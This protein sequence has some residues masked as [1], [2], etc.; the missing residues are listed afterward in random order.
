MPDIRTKRVYEPANKKDGFCVLVDR[1]WPRG[2]KKEQ[3]RSD[4]WLKDVAPSTDLRKWFSHTPSKWVGFKRRYFKELDD[5]PD[6]VELLIDKAAKGRVT[7]LFSARDEQ[8]NQ[9]TA[10]K[11]YLL[12]RLKERAR[13]K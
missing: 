3:V 12:S 8:Y 10:L 1:V 2:L 5:K 11:E 9:A 13:R 6:A 7:L 4:L